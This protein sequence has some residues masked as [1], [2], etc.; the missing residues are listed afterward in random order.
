[1]ISIMNPLNSFHNDLNSILDEINDDSPINDS[2]INDCIIDILNNIIH[3]ICIIPNDKYTQ[4]NVNLIDKLEDNYP[5]EFIKYC[6]DNELKPPTINTSMGK[7]LSC[8][9]HNPFK[10]WTRDDCDMLFKKFNIKSR[11][12]IQAFNKHSQ[13]GIKTNSGIHKGKL[14]IIYPYSLSNKH[15]MR[16]NFK[17]DGS[18]S[19]KNDEINKIKMTIKSDYIDI[20][21]NEWQL[22]HK[23]PGTTDNS[24]NNLVLQPPIQAKYRDNYVFF[25]TLTKFPLPKKLKA[26]FDSKELHLTEDQIDEYC[27]LFNQ[28]KLSVAS[29]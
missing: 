19:Q 7:A 17:F 15:K 23:N 21:N 13:W 27:T 5:G 25:D 20:P 8:M 6:T 9:L 4:I 2:P 14:Y 22:G 16:K 3:S 10:Y 28:I 18:E 1:M 11:D 26:M 29:V 24:S 12:S